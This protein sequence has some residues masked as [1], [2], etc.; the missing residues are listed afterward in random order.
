[1]RCPGTRK[2]VNS[3][4]KLCNYILVDEWKTHKIDRW[5][6]AHRLK[7][8]VNVTCIYK[9]NCRK[10]LTFY[11]MNDANEWQ[12]TAFKI[13]TL[14]HRDIMAAKCTTPDIRE[15]IQLQL[16][17]WILFHI[18]A[19]KIHRYSHSWMRSLPDIHPIVTVKIVAST[20]KY[21]PKF[22]LRCMLGNWCNWVNIYFLSLDHEM[23]TNITWLNFWR[24]RMMW[25]DR[26]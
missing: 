22:N 21:I 24:D 23:E 12:M 2:M 11:A 10:R 5:I 18:A 25:H 20:F 19:I 26:R 4:K 6:K 1:M 9:H 14:W 8:A 3:F 16:F 15:L 17:L 7:C 13:P